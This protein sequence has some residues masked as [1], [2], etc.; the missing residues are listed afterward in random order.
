[1]G[2][3]KGLED[4]IASE[5]LFELLCFMDSKKVVFQL[6]HELWIENFNRIWETIKSFGLI[7]SKQ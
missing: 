2:R 5:L 7:E 4:K 1:M 3:V 6:V